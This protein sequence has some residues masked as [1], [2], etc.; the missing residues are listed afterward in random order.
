MKSFVLATF[1]VCA[2][3]AAA[4]VTYRVGI[5]PH[6]AK[7]ALSDH[8]QPLLDI[9]SAQSGVKLVLDLSET[10]LP[11]FY[12]KYEQGA[13]D[14]ALI[15]PNVFATVGKRGLY[16]ALARKDGTLQG[17]IVVPA[18]S[19]IKKPA[20]L[21]G[22]RLVFPASTSYA[23]VTLTAE[24]LKKIGL[25]SGKD[26]SAEYL[27]SNHEAVYEAVLQGK[28]DAAGGVMNSYLQLPPYKVSGLRV[29]LTTPT[30][31][32]HPFVARD[33]VPA[34]AVSA[35][36]KA[37]LELSSTPA[38]MKTLKGLKYGSFVSATDNDYSDLR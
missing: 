10:T 3:Q 30:M 31:M 15:N 1:M 24:E 9:V 17:I 18:S 12:K 5:V 6:E 23:A 14:F 26:Y 2:A 29:L 32:P 25:V 37:L 35:V 33:K 21:R 7:E 38:G 8:W 13:Y 34:A 22:K 16:H 11:G 27:G 36:K 28:A 20:D 19:P 4:P